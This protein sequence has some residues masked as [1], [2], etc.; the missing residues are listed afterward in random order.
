LI[1]RV[2]FSDDARA[3][4]NAASVWWTLNRD[5]PDLFDDELEAAVI[6]LTRAPETPAIYSHM[7]GLEVRR[8][9]LPRTQFHLYYAI[10]KDIVVV[11]AIW[12]AVRGEPPPILAK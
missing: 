3:Q 4:A 6:R 2:E 8:I 7:A 9:L 12:G 5:Y 1:V 10:A 11:H